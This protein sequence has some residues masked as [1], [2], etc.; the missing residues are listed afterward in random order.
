MLD[1]YTGSHWCIIQTN[2]AVIKNFLNKENTV[3]V[4]F[5]TSRLNSYSFIDFNLKSWFNFWSFFFI[6]KMDSNIIKT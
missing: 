2:K 4:F 5:L 3:C 1:K 6:H